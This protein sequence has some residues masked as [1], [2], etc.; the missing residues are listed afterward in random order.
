MPRR[1]THQDQELNAG[2]FVF[3]E[4]LESDERALSW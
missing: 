4:I 1:E 3:E 2:M